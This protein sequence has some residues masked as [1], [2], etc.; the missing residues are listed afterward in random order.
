MKKSSLLRR[1]VGLVLA[2]SLAF[3]MQS[4]VFAEDTNL[5][6]SSQSGDTDVTGE[7]AV[8]SEVSP[9][10]IITIPEKINFGTLTSPDTNEDDYKVVSFDV[11]AS[12]FVDFSDNTGVAVLVKDS[13]DEKNSNGDWSAKFYIRSE[14][15]YSLEYSILDPSGSDI[16]SGDLTYE[17]G[18]LYNVF[19]AAAVATSSTGSVTVT[20]TAQLNQ[21]QLYGY[22]L[23]DADSERTGTYDGKLNFYA[24]VVDLS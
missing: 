6:D 16:S 23:E 14:N 9:S 22:D 19:G 21:K 1:G 24:K 4:M 17:N 12:S 5:T 13:E 15:S 20:G 2:G 3:G 8:S 7:V 18:L 11:T 10:Y